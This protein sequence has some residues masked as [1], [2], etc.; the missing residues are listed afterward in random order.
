MVREPPA[1]SIV[2]V[3]LP[4]MLIVLKSAVKPAPSATM[5][6]AQRV[7]S[8]QFAAALAVHV[9]STARAAFTDGSRVTLA[10][11][12]AMRRPR[13]TYFDMKKAPLRTTTNTR[14]E[15]ASAFS[16]LRLTSG[17]GVEPSLATRDAA[18]DGFPIRVGHGGKR[19]CV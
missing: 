9:P 17:G 1:T 11:A 19:T 5:P 2:T 7:V 18:H 6:P 4:V 16:T 3:R 15:E 8:L 14:H 12:R 13:E 10:T